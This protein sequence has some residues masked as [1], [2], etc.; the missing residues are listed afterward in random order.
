VNICEIRTQQQKQKWVQSRLSDEVT[1]RIVEARRCFAAP[2]LVVVVAFAD[3]SEDR[4]VSRA[5]ALALALLVIIFKIVVHSPRV[6]ANH[7]LTRVDLLKL[8]EEPFRAL[9]EVRAFALPPVIGVRQTAAV[10]LAVF[11]AALRVTFHN[12]KERAVL[13]DVAG[14]EC[15]GF[16]SVEAQALI[17]WH[18]CESL[19]A[20]CGWL[21]A[22]L[23]GVERIEG[24]LARWIDAGVTRV[25]VLFFSSSV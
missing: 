13:V 3:R 19:R 14:E 11:V 7:R 4:R 2:K 18:G 15:A 23:V 20:A 10:E 5:L 16:A 21:R 1:K 24:A 6:F 12:I 8:H 22:E 25:G 9:A 17:A